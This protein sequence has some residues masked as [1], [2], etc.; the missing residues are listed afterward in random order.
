MSGKPSELVHCRIS[1]QVTIVAA[2]INKWSSKNVV[3]ICSQGLVC[4]IALSWS[5]LCTSLKV[6]TREAMLQVLGGSSRLVH[7]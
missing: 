6:Q 2:Y 3:V 4:F 1:K 5:I 7:N